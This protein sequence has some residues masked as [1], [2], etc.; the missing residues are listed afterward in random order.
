VSHESLPLREQWYFGQHSQF[1][2]TYSKDLVFK[3]AACLAGF[4][5]LSRTAN[6]HFGKLEI[7]SKTLNKA[8]Y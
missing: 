3:D 4:I 6:E 5:G 8:L 2:C 7:C 1:F